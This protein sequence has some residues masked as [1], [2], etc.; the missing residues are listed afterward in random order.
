[1]TCGVTFTFGGLRINPEAAV[2][3]ANDRPI[4]GLFACGSAAGGLF[5]FNYPGGSGLTACAVFG[6]VAGASAAASMRVK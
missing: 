4:P 1:M 6:R 2:I 5:Y 3:G